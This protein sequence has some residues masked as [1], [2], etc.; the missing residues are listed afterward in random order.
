MPSGLRDP[1]EGV[2][3][4]LR[5]RILSGELRPGERILEV[6]LAEQLRLSR[7]PIREALR[8]LVA[9]GLVVR[10]PRLGA[11]VVPI[12]ERTVDEV[13]SLRIA[14]ETFAARR[15]FERYQGNLSL[16]LLVPLEQMREALDAGRPNDVLEPDIA[17]HLALVEAADNGRLLETWRGLVGPLRILLGLTAQRASD[18]H[19]RSL[20][21]HE[22]IY[23][24][25]KA[26]DVEG[27]VATLTEHL[28]TASD[29]VLSYLHEAQRSEAAAPLT[30]AET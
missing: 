12:D 22:Q 7:G 24:R 16:Q 28:Q 13:Y 17:F 26:R 19:R 18:E 15:A 4:T 25:V 3:D 11:I 23:E 14:L 1:W 8:V 2:R 6:P 29:M 9:E 27:T 10:Q 30:T 21:G 20:L 5:A